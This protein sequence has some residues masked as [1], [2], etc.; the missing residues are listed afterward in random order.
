MLYNGQPGAYATRLERDYGKGTVE[1]LES[2]RKL[3]VKMKPEDYEYW[4]TI[5]AEKL[6]NLGIKS[7]TPK[8]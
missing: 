8:T 6:E 7:E 3:V 5:F 2:K 4:I 1:L